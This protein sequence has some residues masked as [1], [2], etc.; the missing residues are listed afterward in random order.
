MRIL[1]V[2]PRFPPDARSGATTVASGLY[3]QARRHHEVRLVAGWVREKTSLPPE[4]VPLALQGVS[5]PAAWARI[6]GAIVRE[7]RVFKPDVVV[8][9]GLGTPPLPLPSV[10]LVHRLGAV[11]G[12]GWLERAR[13]R[14]GRL[15]ARSLR[16][17]IAAS[18]QVAQGLGALGLT[19]ERIRVVLPGV[20]TDRV[21]PTE[22]E[23]GERGTETAPLRFVYPARILPGKGQHHAIDA[24]ARLP[25]RYKRRATLTLAGAVHDR[26][27]LDQLRVQAWG[28]P[29]DF[30]LDVEDMPSLL[31]QHDAVVCPPELGEGHAMGAVEGLGTGLPVIWAD[32]PA[33]REATAGIGLAVPVGDVDALRNAMKRLID[34]ADLR[35]NLGAAGRSYVVTHRSWERVWTRYET[36]LASVVR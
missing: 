27:Y 5:G 29:V 20:D 19:P 3:G 14:S 23:R 9:N 15:Q 34:D 32:Q 18:T 1:F 30:A 33:I 2:A 36:E 10:A 17:V 6:A 25:R 12:R 24:L 4:A 13:L 22:E 26:V 16:R 21:R 7:A 11:T 31:R 35:R 28:Q 8:S